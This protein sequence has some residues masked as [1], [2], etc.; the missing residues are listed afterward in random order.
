MA[1]LVTAIHAP[2]ALDPG[3]RLCVLRQDVDARAKPAHD[4]RE[5]A[6]CGKACSAIGQR[7]L[8]AERHERAGEGAASI[9]TAAGLL[10]HAREQWREEVLPQPVAAHADHSGPSHNQP[11]VLIG[12]KEQFIRG[13]PPARG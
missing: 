1:V 12:R 5:G 13:E 4:E 2:R 11:R 10:A 6:G 3:V 8:G 7:E 9:T